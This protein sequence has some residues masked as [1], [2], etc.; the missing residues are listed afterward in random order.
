M[1]LRPGRL[2]GL[3]GVFLILCGLAGYQIT[4]VHSTPALVNGVVFGGLMIFMGVL[5]SHGRPWTLPASASATGIFT[6]TFLWR[7]AVLW[8]AVLQGNEHASATVA[9]LLTIMMIVSAYVL[10]FLI[11]RIPR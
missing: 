11:K 1:K 7:S 3:Y 6:L 10:Y 8:F 2:T 9:L 4:D 5:L